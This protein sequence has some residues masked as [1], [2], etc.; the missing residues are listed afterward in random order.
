MIKLRLWANIANIIIVVSTMVFM[1]G[2]IFGFIS[3]SLVREILPVI[4]PFSIIYIIYNLY[5][6]L[7]THIQSINTNL[8]TSMKRNDDNERGKDD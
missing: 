7:K 1:L 4:L 6:L 3:E 2:I 8:E 5:A